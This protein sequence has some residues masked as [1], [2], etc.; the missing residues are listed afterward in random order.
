MLKRHASDTGPLC[1]FSDVAMLGWTWGARKMQPVRPVWH[2]LGSPRL[3]AAWCLPR[4]DVC[5]SHD[6]GVQT[7]GPAIKKRTECVSQL[8]L[9]LPAMC[10]MAGQSLDLHDLRQQLFIKL[11]FARGCI[12]VPV[13][14]VP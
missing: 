8:T 13:H 7:H 14:D 1:C 10:T 2:C 9:L 12:V 6:R 11:V 3:Q 4:E 5:A